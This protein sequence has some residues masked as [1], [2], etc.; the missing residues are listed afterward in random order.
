MGLESE[1]GGRFTRPGLYDRLYG[2][3]LAGMDR[4]TAEK[5]LSKRVKEAQNHQPNR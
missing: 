1:R 3:T 5:V 2:R 4:I